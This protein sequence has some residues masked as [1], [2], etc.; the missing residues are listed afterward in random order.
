MG[1]SA[2][3]PSGGMNSYGVN[4]E[5]LMTGLIGGVLGALF[6]LLIAICGGS[7]LKGPPGPRG[8]R[9]KSGKS[10]S[11]CDGKNGCDGCD[12]LRGS[13]IFIGVGDPSTASL[14]C[15]DEGD[16]YIDSLTSN[17]WQ[18]IQCQWVFQA[19]LGVPA[20]VTG[21]HT[22]TG[23]WTFTA[24]AGV[25]QDV[26]ATGAMILPSTTSIVNITENAVAPVV[27]GITGGVAGKFLYLTSDTT[28]G[29][30]TIT[31]EQLLVTA[32]D[33]I[34]CPGAVDAV[35]AVDGACGMFIYDGD[36]QRWR[37][38]NLYF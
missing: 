29:T 34:V 28:T 22:A 19:N 5:T 9:G 6:I 18:F 36:L 38:V 15:A 32:S 30:L 10:A 8:K 2:H 20:T 1:K 24:M 14:P 11:S 27:D 13:Q 21:D 7:A 16:I 35:A 31:H 25:K 3:A 12:G 23:L 33:R 4:H 17:Y 26:A 37:L